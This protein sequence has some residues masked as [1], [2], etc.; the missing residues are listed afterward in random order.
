[1]QVTGDGA[2][3][4]DGV[5]IDPDLLSEWRAAGAATTKARTTATTPLTTTTAATVQ[6]ESQ[7]HE[8]H[9]KQEDDKDAHPKVRPTIGERV[10]MVITTSPSPVN[11]LT[12]F[13]EDVIGSY[14]QHEPEM[15]A[16]PKI[17]VCD[18]V[19]IRANPNKG[20]ER[21]R[22]CKVSASAAA[23]YE[24]YVSALEALAADPEHDLYGAI[25]LRMERRKGFALALKEG[26]KRVH[27][28][29]VFVVQHDR[30]A[31]KPFFMQ[32]MVDALDSYPF[33]LVNYICLGTSNTYKFPAHAVQRNRID[34]RDYARRIPGTNASI[35]PLIFWFDTTHICRTSFYLDFGLQRQVRTITPFHSWQWKTGDF[36]EDKLGQLLIKRVKDRGTMPEFHRFGTFM[37]VFDDDGSLVYPGS[38]CSKYGITEYVETTWIE[39]PKHLRARH[40]VVAHINQRRVQSVMKIYRDSMPAE[41]ASHDALQQSYAEERKRHE[42][43][44][45]AAAKL[46][47]GSDGSDN[48]NDD[49]DE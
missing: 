39:R 26:I 48:D 20:H 27:T 38:R 37:L 1:M 6:E 30:L 40:V 14:L 10:T 43:M 46:T 28:P 9:G 17:I 42:L 12:F 2:G 11:P 23:K 44:R 18:G 34:V 32:N 19:N 21:F 36:V 29:Y 45:Q 15:R 33:R 22:I 31:R 41:T 25:I 7:G 35:V 13:I 4:L 5:E 49:D 16:C 8:H 24:E 47:E 3:A